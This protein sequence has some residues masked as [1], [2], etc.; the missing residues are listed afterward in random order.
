MSGG[1][2][3]YEQFVEIFGLCLLIIGFFLSLLAGSAVLS[4]LIIA[5][6]GLLTGRVLYKRRHTVKIAAYVLITVFLIGYLLGNFYGSK[7]VSLS[8]FILMN[9]LSYHL[10]ATHYFEG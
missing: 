5:T 2:F 6:C 9:L 8:I 1:D 4:Y 10:H 3:V 7:I